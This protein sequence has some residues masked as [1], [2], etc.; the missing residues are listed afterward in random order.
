[1]DSCELTAQEFRRVEA[2]LYDVRRLASAI[3]SLKIK[4]NQLETRAASPPA[5]VS[6]PDAIKVTGGIQESR[7]EKWVEFLDGYEFERQEILYKIRLRENKLET[8]EKVM[9]LLR[10]ENGQYCQL[11]RAKYIN[12][13]RPDS[14]IYEGILFTSRS[15]FYRMRDYVLQAFWDCMP[16]QF[17]CCNQKPW[18]PD[19]LSYSGEF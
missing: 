1:L 4:L 11:V 19:A 17:L 14:A 9:D 3:E 8:Y 10:S 13:I 12:R 2:W 7:L 6:N 5:W 16:G 15:G 18:K